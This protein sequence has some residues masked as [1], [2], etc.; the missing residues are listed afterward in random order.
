MAL[1]WGGGG[2][3]EGVQGSEGPKSERLGQV[4]ASSPRARGSR[5]CWWWGSGL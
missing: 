5:K 4:A 1:F 2:S 3:R